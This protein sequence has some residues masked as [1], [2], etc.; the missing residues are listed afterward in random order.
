VTPLLEVRGLEV[1][2]DGRPLLSRVSFSVA[3]GE[4]V[5]L[6]GP[7]GAGKSSLLAAILGFPPYR[8]TDGRI[9]FRGEDLTS[10]PTH[11]RI[12]RGIGISFQRPPRL[13]GITLGDLA[14]IVGR[15]PALV[16]GAAAAVRMEEFLGREVNAGLSGGEVKRSEIL[17][18]LVQRP[19]LVLLDE[20]D[21]G[22]DLENVALLGRE[23]ERL[24][25]G[26]GALLITHQGHILSHVTA[27]RA[28]VLFQGTI[29][30]QGPPAEILRTIVEKGYAGCVS[31]PECRNR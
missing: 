20:P 15:D 8:V 30:C 1:A 10:L 16:P 7:N 25:Q 26:R 4:T 23:I 13:R 14:G 3:E 29:G 12:A 24:L 5:V 27:D 31:C 2:V 11:Q 17:Q 9:L 6:F 28:L 18:L 22:V 19:D 21:S